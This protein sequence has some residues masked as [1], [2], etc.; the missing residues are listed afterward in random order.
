MR[1]HRAAV[2]VLFALAASPVLAQAPAKPAAQPKTPE[3]WVGV[4]AG[5]DVSPEKLEAILRR[6]G[7]QHTVRLFDLREI[8]RGANGKVNRQR[9]KALMF[10]SR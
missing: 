9:L 6:R 10:E 7:F 5:K 3:M 8:P 4:V 1:V 2:F